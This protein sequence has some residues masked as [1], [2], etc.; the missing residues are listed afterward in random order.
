MRYLASVLRL[1]LAVGMAVSLLS[2]GGLETTTL[3]PDRLMYYNLT[4]FTVDGPNLDKGINL[5]APK[6]SNVTEVTASATATHKEYTCTTGVVGA[7]TVTVVGGNAVLHTTTY[8]V[9]APQVTVKTN[10]GNMVLELDPTAAPN[11]VKNFLQYVADNFY[12]NL[13]FHRVIA[14]FVIQAGGYDAALAASTTRAAIPLEVNNGLSNVRGSVAMA[15]TSAPDSAT[16]QFYINLVDNLNLD[17]DSGGYAVFGK[18]VTGLATVDTIA[19]VPTQASGGMSDVP[20]TPV[21]IS[22]VTQTQ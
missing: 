10:L 12:S 19:A 5:L 7:M 8:Q 11:T 14:G 18:V 22:S 13:I 9:P 3:S 2:C 16:S 17:T 4:H 20:V 21:V 15:R 6:C 1:V